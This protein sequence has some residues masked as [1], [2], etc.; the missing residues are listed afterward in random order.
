MHRIFLKIVNNNFAHIA[1]KVYFDTLLWKPTHQ[2][3]LLIL[4]G[5]LQKYNDYIELLTR[6]VTFVQPKRLPVTAAR[7]MDTCK[8]LKV[9]SGRR[10]FTIDLPIYK[11]IEM[12]VKVRTELN[13]TPADELL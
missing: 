3:F 9:E 2:Q 11:S 7:F 10:N 4:L 1:K 13:V 6:S 12:E 5:L 8:E